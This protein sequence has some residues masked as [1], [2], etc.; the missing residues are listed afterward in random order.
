M[1][2]TKGYIEYSV[3]VFEES[4][5]N[6]FEIF[7]N[8]IRKNYKKEE[9]NKLFY[10]EKELQNYYIILYLKKFS[11]NFNRLIETIKE[12][13]ETKKINLDNYK[14]LKKK[15]IEE[16]ESNNFKLEKLLDILKKNYNDIGKQILEINEF[17]NFL[18]KI[19]FISSKLM[20]NIKNLFKSNDE[21]EIFNS[22]YFK[23]Y[24]LMISEI[25]QKKDIDY[26]E[27]SENKKKLIE[28]INKKKIYGY[29]KIIYLIS[30]EIY[31]EFIEKMKYYYVDKIN[32]NSKMN[33]NFF[34]LYECYSLVIGI[35]NMN[36]ICLEDN[37]ILKYKS[38]KNIPVLLMEKILNKENKKINLNDIK[39]N[40]LISNIENMKKILKNI[41][42]F[43]KIFTIESGIYIYNITEDI[44]LKGIIKQNIKKIILEDEDI[45][46][47]KLE[48]ELYIENLS[49]FT[50]DQYKNLKIEV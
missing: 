7:Y 17:I 5:E 27:Y 46:K 43:K 21:I 25:I 1:Q 10:S 41:E 26:N 20:D 16:I 36:R 22:T 2:N 23:S 28:I 39:N 37:N 3:E 18:S 24:C 29:K 30:N 13:I 48:I 4:N 12:F 50:Y 31:D 32:N 35:L 11:N 33:Y 8:K 14:V 6:F 42:N 49:I 47:K 34:K 40:N 45:L 38:I 9:K 44:Q 15:I 19:N